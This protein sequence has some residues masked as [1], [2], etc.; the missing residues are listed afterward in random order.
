MRIV[1]AGGGTLGSVTPLLAVA[2]EIRRRCPGA[3]MLWVGTVGGPESDPVRRAGL[4]FTAIRSGKL[5]R[6]P[7]IDNFFDVF[8]IIGGFFQSLRILWGKRPEAVVSAGGFVAV[9]V[10][11]AA[12][13]LRIPVHVHQMDIRPGLANR[14]SA[15]FTRSFSVAYRESVRDFSGFRPVWTGNPVRSELFGRTRVQALDFFRLD[16]SLPTVLVL[17]GGTGAMTLNRLAIR[18]A[19]MSDGRI[20]LVHVTGM[21][22]GLPVPEGSDA[23][24]QYPSLDVDR[25]ALAYAVSDLVVTRAGMGTL[26]E[27]AALG[28]PTV[29]I[30]MPHSHQEDNAELF[31]KSGAAEVWPEESVDP[32]GFAD[33]L[34]TVLADPVRLAG[35]GEG[36]KRMNRN[37]AAQRLAEI[38]LKSAGLHPV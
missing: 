8:R 18:A 29:I 28:K 24:R 9:P 15:P 30:P 11:W 4:S 35:L 31:R 17:G 12:A 7:S 26:T 1:F 5:R 25:M 16:G 34:L 3:E 36:M 21:G 10:V 2:G 38:I 13:L 37:D 14:L 32:D 20:N 19:V 23:Y 22:K 6:Y 33:R 27:L